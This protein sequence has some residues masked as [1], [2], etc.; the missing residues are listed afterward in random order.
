MRDAIPHVCI[1]SDIQAFIQCIVDLKLSMAVF[2]NICQLNVV[3]EN[4]GI[5]LFK[6]D[7][8]KKKTSGKT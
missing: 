8:K 4:E 7:E 5:N 2:S 3:N 6:V 1:V